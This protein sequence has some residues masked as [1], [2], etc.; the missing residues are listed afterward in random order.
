MKLLLDQGLPLSAAALLRDASIDTIHVGEIGMSQAE[1]AEIIQKAREEER[2][3]V[4]LDADFHTLLALDEAVSPSVIRVRIERL[5][6]QALM[7]LLL[8]VIAQCE[9]DLEQGSAISIEPSRIRIRRLPL[10]P[11]V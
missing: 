6:A 8:M 5:R 3:V 2:V 10:I 4:T 9:E 1:D 11:D 7:D